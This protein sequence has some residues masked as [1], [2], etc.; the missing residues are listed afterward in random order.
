MALQYAKSVAA[1]FSFAVMLGTSLVHADEILPDA[2]IEATIPRYGNGMG[3]GFGSVW[4][5]SST[6]LGRIRINDNSVVDILL[7]DALGR[8]IF[9]DTVAG[10]G[11]VWVPDAEHSTIYKIDPESNQIVWKISVDLTPRAESLG[12]GEGSVWAICGSGETLK[13]FA[14]TNGNEQADIILPARG[15]GVLVAFGAVWVTSPVNDEVYR[16]DPTSNSVTATIELSSRPRFMTASEG[17]IWAFN[18]GDGSVQRIDATNGKVVASIPTG[19]PEKGTITTGGGYVWA[20]T[21]SSP[22]IQIDPRTNAVQ[23]KY[24][25]STE[26]YGTL[27]Y[28]G[29]SLWLSGSSVRR[30]R[31]PE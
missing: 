1:L 14:A 27:R 13:R 24:H 22:I 25:V 21:R 11:A 26:E 15:F 19:A 30:M 20:S 10:E 12:V 6:S 4:I 23:G 7:P 5:M 8:A 2:R 16:I 18:D 3:V 31:V 9:A 17:S 29:G 28:G